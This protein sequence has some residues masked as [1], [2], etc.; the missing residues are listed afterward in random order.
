MDYTSKMHRPT[1]AANRFAC[2]LAQEELS[3]SL[4]LRKC[5]VALGALETIAAHQAENAGSSPQEG[6][7]Y[8]LLSIPQLNLNLPVWMHLRTFLV[9]C[10]PSCCRRTDRDAAALTLRSQRT[11][12]KIAT[13]CIW[14]EFLSALVSGAC[15][16]RSRRFWIYRMPTS[17]R[18]GKTRHFKP[19]LGMARAPQH[20]MFWTWMLG[21]LT[22]VYRCRCFEYHPMPLLGTMFRVA[23]TPAPRPPDQCVSLLSF[24][25]WTS[26]PL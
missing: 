21:A 23:A 24:S 6:P 1:P 25:C 7:S 17:W 19:P 22:R 18:R 14:S 15:N 2:L 26:C 5:Q 9:R 8:L 3:F 13:C 16:Q 10:C 4:E 12:K 11:G 20:H